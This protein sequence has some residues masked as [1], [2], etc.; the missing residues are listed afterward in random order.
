MAKDKII[1]CKIEPDVKEQFEK[2]C[3]QKYT[4]PSQQ[5]RLLVRQFIS[6]NEGNQVLLSNLK[7]SIK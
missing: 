6:L 5:L 1:S 3:E 7:R 2:L 4:S